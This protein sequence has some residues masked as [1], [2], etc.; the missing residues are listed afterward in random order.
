MFARLFH[1]SSSNQQ[2]MQNRDKWFIFLPVHHRD[3]FFV[4]S[5]TQFDQASRYRIRDNLFRAKDFRKTFFTWFSTRPFLN[6]PNDAALITGS[7][8]CINSIPQ[9]NP[10]VVKALVIPF[11]IADIKPADFVSYTYQLIALV[12]RIIAAN[13]G[14]PIYW[15]ANN[16]QL[17][18]H[19]DDPMVLDNEVAVR[20]NDLAL[21][22]E[23]K[24]MQFAGIVD[25]FEELPK[26]MMRVLTGIDPLPILHPFRHTPPKRPPQEGPYLPAPKPR[27]V[28]T[29]PISELLPEY[30]RP[31]TPPSQARTTTGSGIAGSADG[32]QTDDSVDLFEPLLK[33][34]NSSLNKV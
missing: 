30:F 4:N 33:E 21:E 20:L 3:L 34:S 8:A 32:T 27:L 6:N 7:R 2:N 28:T 11:F 15:I 31:V 24:P 10:P 22:L 1:R 9:Q 17:P 14:L 19:I 26:K 25:P 16:T 23:N 5:L 29:P 12:D 18:T 13:F